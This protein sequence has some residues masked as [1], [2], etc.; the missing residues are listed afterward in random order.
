MMGRDYHR[1]YSRNY[2]HLRKKELIQKLGGKCAECG[3][4]ENL[5]FDHID[6]ENKKFNISRLL[7]R[8]KQA[9]D[10]E[11]Q[12]CQL[13]CHNC[14]QEKTRKDISTKNSGERNYFYNKHR[15]NMPQSKAVVDLDTGEEYVSA[16]EFARVHKLDAD[17]VRRVCRGE[18]N[19]THGFHVHYK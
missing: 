17:A 15:K 16:A 1:N 14:H 6:P 3:S 18:Y 5:E 8:S 12:K 11:L 4:I 10:D 7:N 2:Y 19:S 9:T 13:L